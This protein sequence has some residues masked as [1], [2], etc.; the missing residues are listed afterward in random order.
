MPNLDVPRRYELKLSGEG[1][2]VGKR[3]HV[4]NFPCTSP[5]EGALSYSSEG[6]HALAIVKVPESYESLEK[7]LEDIHREVSELNKIKVNQEIYDISYYLGRD[8][9]FSNWHRLC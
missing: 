9:K 5:D 1:T 6:N 4:V 2:W 3:L 7:A 8:W